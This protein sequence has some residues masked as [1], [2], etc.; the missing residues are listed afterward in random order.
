MGDIEKRLFKVLVTRQA[1]KK[2]DDGTIKI[3]KIKV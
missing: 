1:E 2:L 3:E